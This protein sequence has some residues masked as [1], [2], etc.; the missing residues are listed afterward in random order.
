MSKPGGEYGTISGAKQ[1]LAEFN[2]ALNANRS[3]AERIAYAQAMRQYKVLKTLNK[4]GVIGKDALVNAQ[5][6]ATNWKKGSSLTG[7]G[8]DD[9]GRIAN[10][11]ATLGYKDIHAGNTLQRV[12]ANAPGV[13]KRNAPAAVGGALGAGGL[14]WASGLLGGN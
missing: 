10:S 9:I 6:F 11:F 4:T 14:G 7:Q 3:E 13:L 1:I 8:K 2:A 5:S 12:F